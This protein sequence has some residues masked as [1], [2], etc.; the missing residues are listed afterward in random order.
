MHS[1]CSEFPYGV[2]APKSHFHRLAIAAAIALPLAIMSSTLARAD[3]LEQALAA[4]YQNNARLDVARA[5]LRASDED[6][7]RAH[8]GYRPRVEIAGFRGRR[9]VSTDPAYLSGSSGSDPEGIELTFKQPL[10]R[11]FRTLNSIRQAE[12]ASAAGRHDLA[13]TEARLLVNAAA[14]YMSVLRDGQIVAGRLKL[15]SS[16]QVEVR[17]ARARLSV[18]D[19]TSADLAQAEARRARAIADLESSRADLKASEAL[20]ME[21]VG[22]APTGLT[23]PRPLGVATLPAS[24]EAALALASRHPQVQAAQKRERAAAHAVE[25]VRG[26]LLPEINLEGSK[27]K[28]WR[29]SPDDRFADDYQI[30]AR[31]RMPLYEG[32]EVL[33]RVRKAKEEQIAAAY[34]IRVARSQVEKSIRTAF[35]RYLAA[36]AQVSANEKRLATAQLALENV[37]QEE[38]IGG[39]T[40]LDILN[41]RQEVMEANVA[42]AAA[43]ADYL[44][45]GFEL[46]AA[47]GRL[48]A[49]EL[50]IGDRLYDPEGHL[51]ATRLKLFGTRVSEEPVRAEFAGWR[52]E[53][54]LE[55]APATRG[56]GWV[57]RVDTAR[58]GPGKD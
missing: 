32:G 15:L 21:I 28:V 17:S 16:L 2:G 26:E 1:Y 43:R 54:V 7:A 39:R 46:L 55:G 11:G 51:A 4:A 45:G 37:R 13:D 48:S 30:A 34:D 29:A 22:R 25:V 38:K 20:Y 42:L 9:S 50:G 27:S 23:F 5:R 53:V 6:V 49:A 3:T 44:V 18:Q 41:A 36:R 8:S 10:F 33:A 12:E 35:A 47:S 40:V 24:L 58:T 52:S 19:A 56:E 31:M 57:T 14:A